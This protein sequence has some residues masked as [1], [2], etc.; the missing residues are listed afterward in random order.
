MGSVGKA[1][2]LL[3]GDFGGIGVRSGTAM[4]KVQGVFKGSRDSL[5]L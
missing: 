1:F 4:V 3:R 5:G 2:C